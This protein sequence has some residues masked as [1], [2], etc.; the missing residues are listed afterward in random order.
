MK[1]MNKLEIGLKADNLVRNYIC[2]CGLNNAKKIVWQAYKI[3]RAE[4][5]KRSAK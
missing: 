5:K 4:K 3:L 1:S 2:S